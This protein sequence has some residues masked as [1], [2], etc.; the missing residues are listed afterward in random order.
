MCGGGLMQLV[1]YG[2][3]DVYVY[4]NDIYFEGNSTT[5]HRGTGSKFR[6]KH[7]FYK[8]IKKSGNKI[9]TKPTEI[10]T[11]V[12]GPI[13]DEYDGKGNNSRFVESVNSKSVVP[14]HMRLFNSD[15]VFI[16]KG[17]YVNNNRK[18]KNFEL[19]FKYNKCDYYQYLTNSLNDIFR[20]KI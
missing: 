12:R 17:I 15:K 18:Y 11:R 14:E 5:F 6:G 16:N 10:N 1:A 7:N 2:P 3:W 13:I 4:S 20:T 9:S 8:R 19:L